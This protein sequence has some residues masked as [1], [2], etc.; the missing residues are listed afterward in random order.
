M[1]YQNETSQKKK[2]INN[3]NYFNLFIFFTIIGVF[4]LDRISK[5]KIISLQTEGN[6][7]IF[8]NNYLN[9][10]LVWN[11]GIGFG[12]LSLEASIF[13]HFISALIFVVLCFIVYLI[14][15]SKKIDKF[16]YALILGG[17][18]GNLYDRIFYFAV[19]DFIDMHFKEFHWF[20][21]NIGDIFISIGILL[22]I[23]KE[24][25]FNKK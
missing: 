1:N 21:F 25:L 5:I 10:D 14:F 8:L 7:Y 9:F 6:G 4:T 12:L 13:Y 23:F 17:A 3:I 24:T 19:P 2:F 22:L 18:S 16:L 15:E 11:T 20:T